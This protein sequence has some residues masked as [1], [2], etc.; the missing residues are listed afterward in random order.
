MGGSLL[1]FNCHD[2]TTILMLILVVFLYFSSVT[3][4]TQKFIKENI[5]DNK[6]LDEM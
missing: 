6:I 4:I 3:K 1:I 5:W 2:Y